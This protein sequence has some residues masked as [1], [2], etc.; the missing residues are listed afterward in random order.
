MSLPSLASMS[1]ESLLEE[2][3]V[4]KGK[5][6]L[7]VADVILHLHEIDRR[8]LYRDAGYSSLFSYCHL[9]LGYSEGAANRRVRAARAL[10]PE[11]FEMLRS[12][13]ITL[14]ALSEV[15]P[16]INAENRTEVLGKTEGASKRAAQEIAVEF[17]AAVKPKRACIKPRVVVT[18]PAESESVVKEKRYSI[19]FEVKEHVRELYE[20]A[21]ELIGHCDAAEVFEKTLKEFVERRR[22]KVV[23]Q[24]DPAKVTR[25]IPKAV[26][27]E[28]RGRDDGQCTF[29]SV[30]GIRC[31]ERHGL[32]IDHVVPFALGGSRD[33]SNLQL[34]CRAHNQ[35]RAERMFGRNFIEERRLSGS[36]VTSGSLFY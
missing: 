11:I 29:V 17:G 28:I 1:N 22:P 35:L 12:G 7:V 18:S 5:E 26:K 33:V 13:R 32:E 9:G 10:T 36:I 6:N 4:L 21:K 20:E 15:A 19:S 34:M 23:R 8:G 27:H 16:I 2:T 31:T 3:K 14:C 24:T 30:D 25:Y